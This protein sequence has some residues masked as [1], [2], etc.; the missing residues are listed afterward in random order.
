MALERTLLFLCFAI[1]A[2]CANGTSDAPIGGTG[3]GETGGDSASGL[4]GQSGERGTGGETAAGGHLGGSGAVGGESSAAGGSSGKG[5]VS[6]NGGQQGGST[7]AGHAGAGGSGS[8]GSG[9]GGS[10]GRSDAGSGADSGAVS[11]SKD[12]Q[13]LLNSNCTSCHGGSGPRAGVNL[14]T[15]ASA[16]ANA[17]AANLAIQRGTMPP[18]G[19]LST[20]NKQLF[21]S[22][23]SAGTPSN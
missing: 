13:P 3:G 23:V 16:K 11:Y 4:G 19:P 2:G 21:A 8:G 22:W 12:I 9:S 1:V 10:G 20:V 18:S 7:T 5:G 17:S 6:G 14:S 15:Y